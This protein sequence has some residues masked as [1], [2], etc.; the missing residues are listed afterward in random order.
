MAGETRSSRYRGL[1]VLRY[2]FRETLALRSSSLTAP[3][4]P[5]RAPSVAPRHQTNSEAGSK[6][7]RVAKHTEGL[8]LLGTV[9]PGL[10]AL[11]S[12]PPNSY[13]S[14]RLHTAG[15]RFLH[16]H[17]YLVRPL[18]TS[19]GYTYCLTTVYRFTRLTE[20]NDTP[21][22]TANTVACALLTSMCEQ[23]RT[24]KRHWSMLR[25]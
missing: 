11:Q 6:A 7:F 22:I 2:I 21:Y 18:R 9:L 13:S 8:T 19:A 14:G 16:V 4:V 20:A 3:S 15:S 5:V 25:Y 12:L 10:L 23:I 17:I 24:T 1:H